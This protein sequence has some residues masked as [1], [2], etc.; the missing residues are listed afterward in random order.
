ML[1][2]QNING[3]LLVDSRL[4]A[5]ELGIQHESFKRTLERF[6]DQTEQA[7]GI[8][9]LEVGE[10]VGRGQPEKYYLLTEDQS[11][12]LMTLSVNTTQV[13]QAKLNLVKAF[14]IA[15]KALQQQQADI[16]G[17]VQILQDIQSKAAAQEQQMLLLTE[18]T[19]RLDELE[20]QQ[21]Q[22][23]IAAQEH[24]G[25]ANVLIDQIEADIDNVEMSTK[26]WLDY[27]Q[28]DYRHLHTIARRASA[29]QKGGKTSN[30]VRKN[31][32]GH[33]LIE[34]KYLRQTT[35]ALLNL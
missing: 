29:F 22:F 10:I 17:I 15:K 7:F 13:V 19:Q 11:T 3:Q 8:L 28:L 23:N 20:Q 16:S 25:C 27:L 34:V 5:E 4:I 14:S 1:E 32:K 24:P 31:K 6:K 12:F 21:V 2:I 35:K 18:R 33:T 9:R 26:E 30:A